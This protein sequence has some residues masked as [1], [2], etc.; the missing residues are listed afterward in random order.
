MMESLFWIN[1]AQTK[2]L[3]SEFD[4]IL[5][6]FQLIF[7]FRRPWFKRASSAPSKTSISTAYMDAAGAGKIISISQAVFEGMTNR[8]DEMCKNITG[9]KPGGCRCYT[10]SDCIIGKEP[11]NTNGLLYAKSS[12][13]S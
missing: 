8:T 3:T 1:N 13:M 10:D 9:P 12:L 5:F 11:Y 6:H 7:N 2:Y 4:R